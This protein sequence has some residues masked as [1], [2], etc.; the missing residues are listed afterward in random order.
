VSRGTFVKWTSL[1]VALVLL[2]LSLG[3]A[4]APS[5][6]ALD[7]NEIE[8][9]L[10]FLL[11]PEL[12]LTDEHLLTADMCALI[13]AE[14]EY[15]AIDVIYL[16]TPARSFDREGWINRIRW[17]ENKKKIECT[18]KKRY[19]LS[20]TDAEAIHAALAQA[21]A[22]G[23]RFSDKGFSAE[24]DW[25]YAQMTL[26]VTQEASGKYKDYKSLSEFS[27]ADAAEFLKSTMPKEE[28]NW[29]G[30][31]WG[32]SMLERAQMLGPLRYQRIKGEWEGSEVQVDI[33]PLQDG[34]TAEL[35]FTVS[36][37]ENAA[38]MRAQ[39]TALLEEK[40]VLL[41][42]DSLKTQAILD[43]YLTDDPREPDAVS[44][45]SVPQDTETRG[46]DGLQN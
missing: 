20:G 41:H 46:L 40:G 32:A 45:K 22:D 44:P 39:M 10:K 19:P 12:V 3:F 6:W 9:E 29:G 30:A 24:I 35:S 5:A 23:F 33:W 31:K 21:E 25:G 1:S 4:A 18:Y 36:G 11:D 8:Y 43:G 13:G 17:K 2:I 28:L 37:L 7:E 42:R 14:P 16:E 38:F 15:R 34:C 26:S 27:T